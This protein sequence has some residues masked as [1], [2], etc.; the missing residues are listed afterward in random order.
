MN[1]CYNKNHTRYK[2][3]ERYYNLPP[4]V[5]DAILLDY[6]NKTGL[7][8][9][10]FPTV[11]LLKKLNAGVKTITMSKEAAAEERRKYK[12]H[13]ALAVILKPNKDKVEVT[14]TPKIQLI[15]VEELIKYFT[16][17]SSKEAFQVRA[18]NIN[19]QLVEF[20]K[21][22]KQYSER[23]NIKPIFQSLKAKYPLLELKVANVGGYYNITVSSESEFKAKET[24]PDTQLEFRL[25]EFLKKLGVDVKTTQG[26][27]D[28]EGNIIEDAIAR[29]KYIQDKMKY[30]IELIENK[31]SIDTLPE[32]TAHVILWMMRGTYLYQ[33]MMLEVKGT[34]TYAQ[35]Q[36][37]YADKYTTELEFKEEA[38]AKLIM[39]SIV[40]QHKAGKTDLSEEQYRELSKEIAKAQGIWQ[41]II[42]YLKNLF[43]KFKTNSFDYTA[44]QILFQDTTGLN[45]K[46][47]EEDVSAFQLE[48][49]VVKNTADKLRERKIEKTK[50][51]DSKGQEV[52]SYKEGDFEYKTTVTRKV[53]GN[54]ELIR[55]ELQK[56]QDNVKKEY[57]INGHEQIQKAIIRAVEIK[58]TGRDVP[59]EIV[60]GVLPNDVARI[61]MFAELLVNSYEEDTE[62]LVE[63][64]VGD[65]KNNIAGTIDLVVLYK[66]NGELKM[67][68]Y[69]WKFTEFVKKD[70]KVVYDEM[71]KKKKEEYLEQIKEYRRI[72]E[73]A[74][75]IKAKGKTRL[76]PININVKTIF[77]NKKPVNWEVVNIEIGDL[78]YD[79]LKKYLNPIP[80]ESERTGN[81]TI[82]NI[83][84][85]LIVER[86]K[87]ERTKEI[88]AVNKVTRTNR[89]RAINETIKN[90]IL[91]KNI[92]M[93]L[94]TAIHELQQMML[95]TDISKLAQLNG[96]F[97]FYKSLNFS[98]YRKSITD[99][100]Y[101]NIKDKITQFRD[102]V[103]EAKVI[104]EGKVEKEVE[105]IIQSQDIKGAD[106]LQSDIGIWSKLFNSFST[107]QHPKIQALYKLVIGSKN[108]VKTDLDALNIKIEKALEGVKKYAKD[109]GISST[110]MFK[111][112]VTK[113]SKGN[114][115]LINKYDSETIEAIKKAKEEK[116]YSQLKKYYEFDKEA[117]TKAAKANQDYWSEYYKNEVPENRERL[118]KDKVEAFEKRY[119]AEK[120]VYAYAN[121]GNYYIR[122]KEDL[123]K[124]KEYEAIQNNPELKEFYDLFT[125]F[126]KD[127]RKELGLEYEGGFV[128]QIMQSL[129]EQVNATGVGAIRGLGDRFFNE[130]SAKYQGNYGE[131]NT[132]TGQVD[133]KIPMPYTEK[134][135]EKAS[136]DLGKV[137]SLWGMAYYNNKHMREVEDSAH[138]L[139]EAL[140]LEKLY[141]TDLLGRVKT[142]EDGTPVTKDASSS[143]TLEAFRDFMNEAIYGVAVKGDKSFTMK[144]KRPVWE[145][146][147]IKQ[148]EKG[149]N[150][151]EEYDFEVSGFKLFN[152]VLQYVSGK[153]LGLNF[154]S[155]SANAFGGITNALIEGAKGKYYT[156]KGFLSGVGAFTSGAIN[157]DLLT[158]LQYFDI[159]GDMEG[160]NKANNLSVNKA[161][162]FFSYDKIYALQKGGD[163]LIINSV[164][165]A[166]L[167]SHGISSDGKI[168]HLSQLP[169]GSKS[170][171]QLTEIKDGNLHIPGLTDSE[172]NVEYLKFRRKVL[173]VSKKVMGMSPTYD[174]RL[175][176]QYILGRAFMQFRNWIPRMAD[177]RVGSLKYNVNLE[178]FEQGRYTSFKD[179]ISDNIVKNATKTLGMIVGIGTNT[180]E[181][182]ANKF[183]NLPESDRNFLVTKLGGSMENSA[184]IAKAKDAYVQMMQ[185]NV[186]A[187][188][189]ELQALLSVMALVLLVK[190]GDDDD[191]K[192]GLRKF[193][194]KTVNRFQ[195]ELS[196]F[197]NPASTNAI[198]KSPFAVSAT[199]TDVANFTSHFVGNTTG[200]LVGSKEMQDKYKPIKHIG[201]LFPLTS[202]AVRNITIWNG[203]EYWK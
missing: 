188:I 112:M 72:L 85:G 10:S 55:T 160:F 120:Y 9:N 150:V 51:L 67:D 125:N 132:F 166:M 146:G 102:L 185:G 53:R 111:F 63:Q 60:E 16:V 18:N 133:Y 176:N 191:E 19:S 13:P 29:A 195:D 153:A 113:D 108:K 194:L 21:E 130:V 27:R 144:R 147:K 104:F 172:S 86:D 131:V 24:I 4:L 187:S 129:I 190:G 143:N 32:E 115:R 15:N 47:L 117:Y 41:Q 44:M 69:D 109:K 2:E 57:G 186:R 198:L 80:L 128:P 170:I 126:V 142:K 40:R 168:K 162:K 184:D 141:V 156:R 118:T 134:L 158:I 12:E 173:E 14:Y 105:R 107:Q 124:S 110:D 123:P 84:E 106:L 114:L 48:D 197:V 56:I 100:N 137:L 203:E 201:K 23:V 25:L 174:I 68:I 155:A 97:E 81:K 49:S 46:G 159:M 82:D 71:Y 196:F 99:E 1:S 39:A 177:E 79:E 35:V 165:L 74:Y 76:I 62:F 163:S 154:V 189:M 3:I 70:G 43:N 66:E 116:N 122:L 17:E 77:E 83:I 119:N 139:Y 87:I 175:V 180:S 167:Q 75:G 88:D 42:D 78:G 183:D 93:F 65:K 5:I 11:E 101:N 136:V 193:A 121:K 20:Q 52:N 202:E 199:L 181:I 192:E 200:V 61:E 64:V 30:V 179:F 148:D 94:V 38:A 92:D 127:S 95:E 157:K 58:K 90:L 34:K 26:I 89:L 8:E 59:R 103:D 22:N 37:E 31:R 149:N 161:E 33:K 164:L 45:T 182:F 135:G 73:D 151:Y 152:K 140:K 7:D 28:S 91:T 6:H 138:M 178:E 36:E 50:K 145:N 54:K 169:K 96:S 98:Q 171:K